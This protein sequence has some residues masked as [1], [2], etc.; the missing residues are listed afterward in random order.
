VLFYFIL[1]KVRIYLHYR[2]KITK[3]ISKIKG[4]ISLK[5]SKKNLKK[6]LK[7]PKRVKINKKT[8]KM[9]FL[10]IYTFSF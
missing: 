5:I 3:Q 4:K 8:Q 1:K 2:K 9:H 7:I 6:S 10:C